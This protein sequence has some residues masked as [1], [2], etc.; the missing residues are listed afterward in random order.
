M[1]RGELE[2]AHQHGERLLRE[3]DQA[4]AAAWLE[5][6]VKHSQKALDSGWRMESALGQFLAI[7]DAKARVTGFLESKEPARKAFE[8]VRESL[9]GGEEAIRRSEAEV[10]DYLHRLR[11]RV[12]DAQGLVDDALSKAP[13]GEEWR[14]RRT[15]EQVPSSKRE[16]RATVVIKRDPQK[17]HSLEDIR[18]LVA[19]ALEPLGGMGAFVKEGQTVLIKPNLTLFFLAEV[20]T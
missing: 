6:V 4:A 15:K 2:S 18:S 20:Q 8:L 12:S 1:F 9:E 16:R 3:V 5:D 19:S 13:S 10:K 11:K 17:A 14:L 7:D